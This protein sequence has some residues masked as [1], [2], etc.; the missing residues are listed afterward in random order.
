M[1][2]VIPPI[3][4]VPEFAQKKEMYINVPVRPQLVRPLIKGTAQ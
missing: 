4:D 1:S 2:A 3:T